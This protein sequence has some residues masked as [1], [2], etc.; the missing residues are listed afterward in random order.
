MWPAGP[1]ISNVGVNS[2]GSAGPAN[3]IHREPGEQNHKIF[4]MHIY[5]SC[6]HNGDNLNFS[7][8]TAN[9]YKDRIL[10]QTI[11]NTCKKYEGEGLK[12]SQ[13]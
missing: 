13:K 10:P 4:F 2:I 6:T 5:Y 7:I 8:K 9:A 11:I 3:F 12:Q 1:H